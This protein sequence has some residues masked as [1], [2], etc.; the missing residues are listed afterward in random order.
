MV[1]PSCHVRW[2]FQIR[3][4]FDASCSSY[5]YNNKQAHRVLVFNR[6]QAQPEQSL[7]ALQLTAVWIEHSNSHPALVRATLQKAGK[8]KSDE[9]SYYQQLDTL[10][11][12]NHQINGMVWSA[13]VVKWCLTKS[14]LLNFPI[15]A[16]LV[17]NGFK[18]EGS[19]TY[20]LTFHGHR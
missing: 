6:N 10:L 20:A 17:N 3:V 2:P 12:G 7:D 18:K 5:A 8:R 11:W 15:E 16:G 14:R 4:S 1:R 13:K 19:L 9:K